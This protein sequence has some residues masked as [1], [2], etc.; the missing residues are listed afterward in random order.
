MT[1]LQL[2]TF[3]QMLN[4]VFTLFVQN[5]EERKILRQN[6]SLYLQ[7]KTHLAHISHKVFTTI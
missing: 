3:E 2:N 7:I 5:P 4:K 6:V 1:C